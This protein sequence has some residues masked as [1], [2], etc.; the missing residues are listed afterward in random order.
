RSRG[1]EYF[2]WHC[3]KRFGYLG[4]DD[5]RYLSRADQNPGSPKSIRR[6]SVEEKTVVAG[7]RGPTRS[8]N[9]WH[10]L[11]SGVL[12]A[13]GVHTNGFHAGARRLIARKIRCGDRSRAAGK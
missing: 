4:P 8:F 13:A 10:C 11:N 9:E 6:F 2:V 1:R 3:L 7:L 5:G 12:L